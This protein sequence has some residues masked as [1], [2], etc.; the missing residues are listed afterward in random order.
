MKLII[1]SGNHSTK[2]GIFDESSILFYERIINGDEKKIINIIKNFKI[3]L[4]II[5]SVVNEKEKIILELIS[6]HTGKIL[7]LNHLTKLPFINR[8]ETPETLGKDRVAAIAGAQLLFPD[9]IYLL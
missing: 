5:S 4:T 6:P 8:Y 1:D 9:K 2:I 3:D 7:I